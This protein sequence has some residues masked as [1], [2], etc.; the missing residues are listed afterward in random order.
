METSPWLV[1]HQPKPKFVLNVI[2]KKPP[3]LN[4]V[5]SLFKAMILY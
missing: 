4:P 5:A 1:S 3:E 2:K